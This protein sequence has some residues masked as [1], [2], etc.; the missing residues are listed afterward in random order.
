MGE[1]GK[2]MQD[3]RIH[4]QQMQQGGYGY[5]ESLVITHPYATAAASRQRYQ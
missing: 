2:T 1:L 3:L 4:R 5:G